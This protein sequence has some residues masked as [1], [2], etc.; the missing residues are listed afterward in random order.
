MEML[1][2]GVTSSSMLSVGYETGS[3]T[4]EIE[5]HHGQVYQYYDVPENIHSDLLAAESHGRF[6]NAYFRKNYRFRRV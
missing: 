5:F 4:L 3:M 2:A 6:F 1:R